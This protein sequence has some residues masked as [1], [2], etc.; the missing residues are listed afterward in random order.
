MQ[1]KQE[2]RAWK[3][4]W[5]LRQFLIQSPYHPQGQALLTSHLEISL[6]GSKP[7]K[8]IFVCLFKICP[9]DSCV[10]AQMIIELFCLFLFPQLPPLVFHCLPY[11][12]I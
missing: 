5:R 4:L 7:W 3:H 12:H 2:C 8:Y 11:M 6:R 10:T 9:F 1:S